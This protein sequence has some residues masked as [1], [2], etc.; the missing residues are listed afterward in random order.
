MSMAKLNRY[1]RTDECEVCGV[2][3]KTT[4]FLNLYGQIVHVFC[5]DCEPKY[6]QK[7]RGMD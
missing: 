7:L 6:K 3:G 2:V 5:E 1:R 4:C